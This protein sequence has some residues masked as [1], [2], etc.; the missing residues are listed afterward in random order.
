MLNVVFLCSIPF[1]L[2]EKKGYKLGS[3]LLDYLVVKSS[4]QGNV[5]FF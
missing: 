3:E 2:N 4:T 1:I 5:G